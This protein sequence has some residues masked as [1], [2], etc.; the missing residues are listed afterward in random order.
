M[1]KLVIL[2]IVLRYHE[3]LSHILKY[4]YTE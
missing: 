3:I 1:S 2:K 4:L